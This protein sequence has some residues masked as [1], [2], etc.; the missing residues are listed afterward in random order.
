MG[1]AAGLQRRVQRGGPRYEKWKVA[2]GYAAGQITGDNLQLTNGGMVQSL[3]MGGYGYYEAR[4]KGAPD[5]LNTRLLALPLCDDHQGYDDSPEID[6]VEQYGTYSTRT[7]YFDAYYWVNGAAV[8]N[9]HSYNVRSNLTSNYHVYGLYWTPDT[10]SWYV[11]GTQLA[12]ISNTHWFDPE[13]INLSVGAADWLGTPTNPSATMY[14][15]YVASGRTQPFL[16]FPSR[17]R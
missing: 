8:G 15:D 12:S 3:Q 6:I 7:A 11:D 17:A 1:S 9:P 14:V 4:M 2:D 16:P 10:L 13:G 5:L